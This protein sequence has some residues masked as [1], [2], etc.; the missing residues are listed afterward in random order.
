LLWDLY[1]KS[2]KSKKKGG[3]EWKVTCETCMDY[4]LEKQVCTIRYTILKDKSK[5]P[6][7]RKP[8]QKS[9]EVYLRK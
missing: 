9:C 4:D 5:I 6:M 1:E 2:K 7:K 3:G 8:N